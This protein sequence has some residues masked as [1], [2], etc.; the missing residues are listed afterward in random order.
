M[1][2]HTLVT[3]A[4]GF[5]GSALTARLLQSGHQVTSL[6]RGQGTQGASVA[7]SEPGLLQ[8]EDD[9]HNIERIFPAGVDALVHLAARVHVRNEHGHEAALAHQ[10]VN[11]DASVRLALAAREKGVKRLVFVSSIKALGED[12]KG[13]PLRENDEAH[14]SDDYGRSKLAAEESLR[15]LETPDFSVTIVR[16]PLVYGPGV[17]ANFAQLARAVRHRRPLP[18]G[19]ARAPRSLVGLDNAV[20][21]LSL[22]LTH[23][24]A[25]GRT[26]HVADQEAPTVRE[27]VLALAA[28]FGQP[29][30]LFNV[31]LP[32]L[33]ALAQV[34]RRSDTML[35]LI[36]PL[37][38]DTTLIRELLGWSPPLSLSAGL[39]QYAASTPNP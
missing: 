35:R 29:A 16:L 2:A 5:I 21:A 14:P 23:P 15:L 18:L 25:A 20:S 37:R 7:C 24:A 34:A 13:R 4:R 39:A 17:K 31:P 8:T 30:R 22:C 6:V 1:V 3:G 36:T 33:V 27:L 10:R 12:D 32:V 9:F 28:A 19:Q 38:L 26:F 11:H